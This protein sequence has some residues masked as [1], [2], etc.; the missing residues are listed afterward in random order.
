MLLSLHHRTG[1][2]RLWQRTLASTRQVNVS[3]YGHFETPFLWQ[4]DKMQARGAVCDPLSWDDAVVF[5]RYGR[6]LFARCASP[7]AL[8]PSGWPRLLPRMLFGARPTASFLADLARGRLRLDRLS[9][10]GGGSTFFPWASPI[11]R[12]ARKS[13]R[14]HPPLCSGP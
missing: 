3:H 11:P 7:L 2:Q 1:W 4:A 12:E 10:N 6:R 14:R 5:L 9:R 8:G 13:P